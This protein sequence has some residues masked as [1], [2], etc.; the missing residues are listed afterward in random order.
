[1]R[2]QV[3]YRVPPA[4]SAADQQDDMCSDP[5]SAGDLSAPGRD[6]TP[7]RICCQERLIDSADSATVA[8]SS[9]GSRLTGLRQVRIVQDAAGAAAAGTAVSDSSA[10]GQA[11]DLAPQ[12]QK[13]RILPFHFGHKVGHNPSAEA[14]GLQWNS[15][16]VSRRTRVAE[17][18]QQP[19]ARLSAL[20]QE[21][22]EEL[23]AAAA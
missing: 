23:G 7:T 3:W 9:S 14:A 6:S 18:V 12:P 20:M 1:M 21:Q 8:S 19:A 5:T 13:A 15:K 16:L 2:Q 17:L 10:A 4:E 22:I 11:L